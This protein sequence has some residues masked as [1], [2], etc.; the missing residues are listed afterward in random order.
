VITMSEQKT[1]EKTQAQILRDA[2]E[3]MKDRQPKA[4]QELNERLASDK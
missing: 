4:D 1:S 3:G 2:F